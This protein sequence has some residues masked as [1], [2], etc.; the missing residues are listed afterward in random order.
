MEKG[1]NIKNTVCLKM[2]DRNYRWLHSQM[3]GLEKEVVEAL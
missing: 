1:R 3:F 2:F